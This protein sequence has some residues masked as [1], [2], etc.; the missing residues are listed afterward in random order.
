MAKNLI[1]KK[2]LYLQ[3]TSLQSY[4]ECLRCI[5]TPSSRGS[6]S[7]SFILAIGGCSINLVF[8]SEDLRGAILPA[9]NHLLSKDTPLLT[10]HLLDC[11]SFPMDLKID[12]LSFLPRDDDGLSLMDSSRFTCFSQAEGSII[13]IIDWDRN[14]AY[15]IVRSHADLSYIERSSPLRSLLTHWLGRQGLHLVHGAAVGNDL[16]SVLILGHGGAGKSTTALVCL[17]A[18]LEYIADDHC[19]VEDGIEPMVHSLFST[20]KLAEQQLQHFP[21][22]SS[23]SQTEGRPNEEKVVLYLSR[24]ATLPLKRQLPLRAILLAH[25]TGK[26]ETTI[27][28]IS[29]ARAFKAITPSCALHFPSARKSA[30]SCFGRLIKALP[31]YTLELGTNHVSTPASIQALLASLSIKP[32]A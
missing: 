4:L 26:Q 21:M 23:T 20:G 24:L 3:I 14:E 19:V 6:E 10:L 5:I 16:G 15:W 7:N 12:F 22:L 8:H 32:H 30:L 31:T 13:S 9:F 27:L 17:E 11:S 1:L 2:P 29:P 25:I 18:G 28:K